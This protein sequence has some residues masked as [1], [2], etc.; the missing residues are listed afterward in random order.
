MRTIFITG[1]ASGMGRAAAERFHHE[2][3][4]VGLIDANEEALAKVASDL[5]GS[6]SRAVD[7]CDASAVSAAVD[8]FVAGVDGHL[9]VVY[10]CA[11]ILRTGDFESIDAQTHGL[12]IDINVKGVIHVLLACH[13]ALKNTPG[14]LVVNMSSASALYGTPE[15]ASY[16]ASKFAVRALTEA[17]DLEWAKDGIQVVDLMPPFVRG[18]MSDANPSRFAQKMGVNLEPS[19]VVNVLHEIVESR[20]RRLHNPVTLSFKATVLAQKIVPAAITRQVMRYLAR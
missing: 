17:L 18:P 4:R 20:Q 16:S 13:K 15:F 11:G 19:D 9:H 6:W 5:P 7:V 10:N 3:W 2:G 12:L 1:A 14:S 8:D